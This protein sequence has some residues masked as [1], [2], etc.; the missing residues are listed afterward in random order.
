[1]KTVRTVAILT[2]VAGMAYFACKF[3]TDSE[4]S[5]VSVKSLQ[6]KDEVEQWAQGPDGFKPFTSLEG[7][8]LIMNGGADEYYNRG[9]IEGFVQF[10]VKSGTEYTM[11][12]RI[13]DFATA[14]NA[15]NIYLYM[16]DDRASSKEDAGNYSQDDAFID[17]EASLTGCYGYA[18]FGQ[19]YV[20]LLFSGYSSNKTEASR[21]ATSFIE[22]FND[23]ID[24]M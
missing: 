15:K 23:K 19:Y 18:H 24:K 14:E 21:N 3:G 16:R 20:E 2:M 9:A 1:M 6:I 8:T 11:E 13:M 12:S 5:A 22:V 17:P 10:M 7:L 4:G